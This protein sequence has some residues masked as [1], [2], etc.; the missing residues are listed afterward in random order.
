MFQI[1]TNK[2]AINLITGS[3]GAGKTTLLA[4]MLDAKPDNENWAILV[5]EFGAIGIDGAILSNQH[6]SIEVA[7]IPGG[8]ICCTALGEFKDAIQEL[9][10]NHQLDRILIEPTGI[11]EPDSMVELLH[12]PYFQK[13]F[14]IQTVFAVLDT[15]ATSI[16]LFE[17]LI[18]MQNLVDV[19]D[20][21]VLN[22]QDLANQQQITELNDYVESLYP[23]KAAIIN[24]SKSKV[25]ADL[26]NYKSSHNVPQPASALTQSNHS[27]H[28]LERDHKFKQI[29][30]IAQDPILESLTEASKLPGL[31]ERK[32]Q[33]QLDT[34]SIGWIFSNEVEFEWSQVF[35]LFK[36]LEKITANS[37]GPIRAKGLFKVGEP[38]MLFQWVQGKPATRDYNAYKRDSRLEILLPSE[39]KFDLKKFESQLAACIKS[40]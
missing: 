34:I 36:S 40:Q 1:I 10:Q 15:S 6:E 37:Q 22:K 14:D 11:G 19:A 9:M 26:L 28:Q 4:N 38:R 7:E 18:I 24:T 39:F 33:S 29:Q 23:P 16:D 21:V 17:K 8:C 30:P 12:T 2:T 27:L 5:N 25:N 3:L 31:I 32:T 35:Q 13:H 20:V